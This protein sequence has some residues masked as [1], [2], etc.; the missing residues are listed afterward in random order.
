MSELVYLASPYSHPDPAVREA[1]FRAACAAAAHLMRAGVLVF[2]PIAHT[3]PIAC[4]GGLPTGWEF[5]ERY[6]RAVLAACGE[7]AVLKLPG[8]TES[9]GIRAEIVIARELGSPVRYVEPADVGLA[10]CGC[11]RQGTDLPESPGMQK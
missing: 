10:G 8:W 6:D 9:K 7:L 1:R 4:A 11:E 2:S 5:W 3:H